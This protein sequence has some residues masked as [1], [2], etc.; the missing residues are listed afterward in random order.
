MTA[1]GRDFASPALWWDGITRSAPEPPLE[2]ETTCQYAIV[3]GGYT[4]LWTAYFLKQRQPQADIVL[5]D[6]QQIGHGASGRNGGWLMGS[7][8]GLS[9]FANADG[10]LAEPVRRTLNQLVTDAG[11]ALSEANIDCDFY[12]GDASWRRHDSTHKRIARVRRS[13]ISGGSASPMKTTNGCRH[14]D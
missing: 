2:T 5:V 9:T 8:E 14:N 1:P 4:G 7:L 10:T 11:K 12:H 3:G 13:N 6:A